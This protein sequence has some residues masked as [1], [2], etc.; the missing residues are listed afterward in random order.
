MIEY[1]SGDWETD[2]KIPGNFV[3][4][5]SHFFENVRHESPHIRQKFAERLLVIWLFAK[6]ATP[7]DGDFVECGVF[8]GDSAYFMAKNC[9]TKLHLF[10]S[11]E[12]VTDFTE[13]DNEFYKEMPFKADMSEAVET[14]AEF[15]NIEFHNGEVP[16]DFDKV[17][18]ISLL[19]IDMDNYNP[20]KTA[21]E[22][23]WNKVIDG[24]I[25][26]VDF[27]DSVAAGAEKATRDFFSNLGRELT[28]F[29]TGKAVVIK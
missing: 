15:E 2:L 11:W 13:F 17:E 10:D 22:G 8:T 19:H 24:G 9:N 28:L 16:F 26:M 3:R 4:E 14:L 21:L 1:P 20:T 27:H 29:P 6:K 12:G 25:V 23:L 18:K 7:L 5:F